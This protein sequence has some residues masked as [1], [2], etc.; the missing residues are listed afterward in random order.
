[1][2]QDGIADDPRAYR[3]QPA[4]QYAHDRSSDLDRVAFDDRDNRW[5]W[6]RT[7]LLLMLFGYFCLPF[8]IGGTFYAARTGDDQ[9]LKFVTVASLIGMAGPIAIGWLLCAMTPAE[10]GTSRKALMA[11]VG[12][13]IQI[14]TVAGKIWPD[15]IVVPEAF[16]TFRTFISV[17]TLALMLRYLQDTFEYLKPGEC[18]RWIIALR[19]TTNWLAVVLLAAIGVLLFV[20]VNAIPMF[21]VIPFLVLVTIATAVTYVLFYGSM[22]RLWVLLRG[23]GQIGVSDAA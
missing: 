21:V 3:F 13:I 9:W 1:M 23:E 7:G 14:W 2:T 4:G 15:A 16:I 10:A 20:P 19:R 12:V 17:L 22:F 8:M 6:V 5:S 18:D 11:A